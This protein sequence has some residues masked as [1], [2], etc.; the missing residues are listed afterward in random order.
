LKALE[1]DG[2]TVGGSF[3]VSEKSIAA[4]S[5]ITDRLKKYYHIEKTARNGYYLKVYVY[6]ADK[7]KLEAVN[8]IVCELYN[9]KYSQVLHIWYFDKKNFVEAYLKS[10]DDPN[11][12]DEKFNK[13]DKHLLATYEKEAGSTGSFDLNK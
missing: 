4:S 3:A 1:I 5:S 10:I 8:D 12:S 11:T 2:V 9:G 13:M 6:L 7:S